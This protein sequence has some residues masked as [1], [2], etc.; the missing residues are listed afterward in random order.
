MNDI[1]CDECHNKFK[2]KN[3][4]KIKVN[5]KKMYVCRNCYKKYKRWM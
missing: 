4:R 2:K 5:K 1:E 3:I